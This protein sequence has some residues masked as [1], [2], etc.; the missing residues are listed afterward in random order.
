MPVR[1]GNATVVK[2]SESEKSSA[3][4]PCGSCGER[5]RRALT[6]NRNRDFNTP[7]LVTCKRVYDALKSGP[8]QRSRVSPET[9]AATSLHF[10]YSYTGSTGFILTMPN[11]RLLV[12]STELDQAMES[13]LEMAKSESSDQIAFFSKKF[14]PRSVGQ[15]Y[16][17]TED[18]IQGGMGADIEW[19][20]DN[21]VKANL[22]AEILQLENLRQA[23]A[24]TS[25]EFV[26]Q[27]EIT[28]SLVGYDTERH[29]FHIK[30]PTGE[31]IRGSAL[32]TIGTP[33]KTVTLP[34]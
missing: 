3:V 27:F 5:A 7:R 14:G 21:R 10:G 8:K 24:E 13:V 29:S 34:K 23:I 15:M 25:D 2:P 18:H 1:P 12:G 19:R 32:E 30:L 33:D 22:F 28:A 16:K 31:E 6:Q 20:R 11:E 17:W 4:T 26:E 9:A